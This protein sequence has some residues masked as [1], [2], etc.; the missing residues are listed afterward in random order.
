MKLK[1]EYNYKNS[2]KPILSEI[3]LKTGMPI[4]ILE[5]KLNP[6][7]GEMIIDVPASEDQLTSI[8]GLFEEAGVTV[9]EMT[10]FIEIDRTRCT[11]CGACVSSCPVQAISQKPDWDVEY[12]DKKCIRCR[13]CITACPVAAIKLA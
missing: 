4:N 3:I 1:L 9:K 6:D 2:G 12:D 10:E 5:A 13:I 11:S 8:V 7:S